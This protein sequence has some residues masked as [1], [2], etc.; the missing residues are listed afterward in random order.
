M[1]LAY[2]MTAEQY[3]YQDPNLFYNYKK[4]FELKQELKENEFW[5]QGAY[6][7]SALSSTPLWV[8]GLV[9]ANKMKLADFPKPPIKGNSIK[10][11]ILSEEQLKKERFRVYAY[12]E[13]IHKA[14]NKK[15]K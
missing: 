1:G 14:N 11:E 3:F 9:E 12:F 13:Q 8:Y 2:G 15:R 10:D 5:I 4:A 7:K 6:I